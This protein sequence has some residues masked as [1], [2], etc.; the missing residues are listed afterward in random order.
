M[1]SHMQFMEMLVEGGILCFIGY[2]AM[3]YGVIRAACVASARVTDGFKHYV[4]AAA[5][6]ISGITLIGMFE[7]CWFYPRVMCAFFI[8]VGLC[9]AVSR[10]AE[11]S[12]EGNND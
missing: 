12:S 3:A 10:M 4:V 1:H 9:L 2:I 6:S 11:N 5:A 8:S 7:Y